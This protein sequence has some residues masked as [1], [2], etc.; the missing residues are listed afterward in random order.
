MGKNIYLVTGGNGWLGRRVVKKLLDENQEK[1]NLTEVICLVP[2]EE[3]VSGLLNLGAK[4]VRGGVNDSLAIE[5]FMENASGSTVIHLA[6][7]IHPPGKSSL[8][9]TVNYDGTR[10][11]L[12]SAA[13]KGAKRL[14]V[15]SSNS[16]FGG[17]KSNNEVFDEDALYNPYMGYGQSKMLMEKMLLEHINQKSSELEVVILRAPWFYG[18]GQPARQTQFFTMIKDGKFPIIGNG[19]N[20]RSMGYV[21]NLADGIHLASQKQQAANNI[22]WIA[23]E[24][25]Y[26]MIEII[27]TVKDVLRQ[28]FGMKVSNRQIYLPSIVS[29]LARVGD[30]I[31][32]K[33]G[34][35][36]QKIHVLSEMNMTIACDISKAKKIL[37]Y[38]PS[39]HLMDGMRNSID[40]FLKNKMKI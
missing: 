8:F 10:K 17:N 20:K 27:S 7:I 14:I 3:D 32:Q 19:A 12:N 33:S 35:Y 6:G 11:V 39:V 23:D 22:F 38:A 21:D 1:S 13:Q 36:N 30:Y 5:A 40:W 16:P 25:P 29:D 26:S 9:I 34:L 4:V 18:P 15:M 31:L 2:A 37:S 24:K 28:D